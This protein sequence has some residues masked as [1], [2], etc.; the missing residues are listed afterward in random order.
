MKFAEEKHP[1]PGPPFVHSGRSRKEPLTSDTW[2]LGSL[3]GRLQLR[4]LR[5]AGAF[6]YREV[7]LPDDSSSSSPPPPPPP[8]P[9]PHLL[10]LLSLTC[11][12][13]RCGL[14]HF[15]LSAGWN[16]GPGLWLCS[17]EGG[18]LCQKGKNDLGFGGEQTMILQRRTA[19]E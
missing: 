10:L 6:G 15:P 8:L 13:F 3:T 19:G 14:F 1:F 2:G 4:T 12:V 17:R 5:R 9:P 7:R 16:P 18:T 11:H